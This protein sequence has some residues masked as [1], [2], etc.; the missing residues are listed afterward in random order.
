[1]GASIYTLL[2]TQ[3]LDDIQPSIFSATS[4][5]T[6]SKYLLE[7]PKAVN[8]TFNQTGM[9]KLMQVCET[10]SDP[11]SYKLALLLLDTIYGRSWFIKFVTLDLCGSTHIAI[12]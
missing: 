2:P 12:I 11:N 3:P 7:N 4:Y 1:M 6:L 5:E 9:T 8:K 10:P